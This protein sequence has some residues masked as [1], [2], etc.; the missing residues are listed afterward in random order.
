M[1]IFFLIP[2]L[3][4]SSMLIS[5]TDSLALKNDSIALVQD[6]SA[7]LS[8]NL[9]A[10]LIGNRAYSHF[11]K[12]DIASDKFGSTEIDPTGSANILLPGFNFGLEALIGQSPKGKLILGFSISNTSAKYHYYQSV[13]TRGPSVYNA[14]ENI[15]SY[16]VY[17]KSTMLN[18]ECGAKIKLFKGL[19]IKNS[20][21]INQNLTRI[22][23]RTGNNTLSEWSNYPAPIENYYWVT[24]TEIN[25]NGSV[26]ALNLEFSYRLGFEYDLEIKNKQIGLFA[27]RNFGLTKYLPWWGIGFA[28]Y[29]IK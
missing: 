27:F 17:L 16:D 7:Y 19:F 24:E 26:N 18:Y 6:T 21:L 14:S 9:N 4:S 25:S 2:F 28:Y 23:K 29:L 22:E 10:S 13:L 5:Q 15:S 3:I 1:R 11:S 12:T 8:V 20:I